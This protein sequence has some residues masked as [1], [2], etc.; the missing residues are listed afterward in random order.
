MARADSNTMTSQTIE[1]LDRP[2]AGWFAL[3]VMRASGPKGS[4]VALMTDVELRDLKNCV[5][6]F[7]ALF[8]VDPN[9][10]CPG[11][12]I[13]RQCW[14][15]ISGKHRNREAARDALQALVSTRH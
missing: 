5:C 7:P 12:R 9:E 15:R 8:Y 14:V 3:A 1:Y 2:P 10:Y 13:A 4:W 6:D 11:E